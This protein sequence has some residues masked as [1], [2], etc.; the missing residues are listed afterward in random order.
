MTGWQLRRSVG[1]AQRKWLLLKDYRRNELKE[2]D[3]SLVSARW[4]TQ[5]RHG[6]YS[7]E[8]PLPFVNRIL[9]ALDAHSLRLS[10]G[11]Y[12][13]CGNGRNYLPLVNS[14]LRLYGLDLSS[15]SLS[16]LE[17]REPAIS[18]RLIRADFRS[19]RSQRRFGYIIAIQVFQHGF[20][21]DV[22][23][24]FA[25]VSSML[26]P[27]GLFF[28]RVNAA[29]TQIMQ[30]H[31]IVEQNPFG[32]M[33]ILYEAGPKQGLPV[34]FYTRDELVNLTRDHFDV[35]EELHEDITLRT[36]PEAGYWVQWEGIWR[37]RD[38]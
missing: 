17:A 32:G 25:N 5:Y 26:S 23:R 9:P 38:S 11:L 14:G 30:P 33:T 8:P 13:G 29:S 15:E 24:Y 31:T 20:G 36:P 19:Y 35:V 28:L 21:A 10:T 18:K 6:R 16:Q 34:H 2:M 37:Y 1:H 3:Q 27:G 7:E 12:I 4:D 22:A